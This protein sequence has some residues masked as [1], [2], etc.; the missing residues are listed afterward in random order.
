MKLA[1]VFSALAYGELSQLALGKNVE[2]E[3]EE[4]VYPTLV[5]HI[6]LGLTSIYKRFNLKEGRLL[7]PLSGEGNVYKLEVTDIHK[8]ERV[9]THQ[10]TELGLNNESDPY[11]CFTPSMDILRV[12][13]KIVDQSPDLPDEYKTTELTVIYRANHPKLIVKNGYIDPFK[14]TLE[15][16]YSHLQA[17]LYFVASRV[18]NPIGMINEFHSG[19]SWYAK[20]EME[21]Q[22]LEAENIEIDESNHNDRLQRS[23][24]V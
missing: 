1:E 10:G 4:A 3:V 2:G 24:W 23:G 9:L 6:N 12:P 17:L 5:S 19:N 11:A 21:C 14:T 8:I 15:L 13:Q 20:Y 16:P 22:R 7:F 18:H